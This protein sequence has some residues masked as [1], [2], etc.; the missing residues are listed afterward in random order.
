MTTRKGID[1]SEW[2]GVIDWNKVKAAGIEF[3][4]LRCGFGK[5]STQ[6]DNYFEKNYKNAKAAGVPVGVYHYSYATTIKDAEREADFCLSLLKGK[7]FEYPIAYDV[8]DRTQAKLTVAQ[9]SDIIRAFCGKLEKAGYFV[10]LYANKSWLEN[11]IDADCRKRYDVWLAQWTSKPTY[12]SQFG[13]WQYS[14]KGKVNG[15]AGNVDMNEAY[16]DYPTIIKSAKLNGYNETVAAP[17]PV[18]EKKP[19]PTPEKKPAPV[20]VKYKA[21]QKIVLKNTPIYATASAKTRAGKKSG[22]YYIY[23][24]VKI[25]GR[26]RVTNRADRVG[27]KPIWANVTGFVAL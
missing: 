23:D 19:A 24:G 26:Y 4:M 14:S 6:T 1:V 16:K 15:I 21:G 7:Q 10:S 8:E 3:A 27:K 11:K 18:P 25:N 13:M 9:L 20:V 22:T 5:N 12:K 2:Q 17:A